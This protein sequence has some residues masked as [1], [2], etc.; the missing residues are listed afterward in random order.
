VL[1]LQHAARPEHGGHLVLGH[2]D[3]LAAQ[4]GRAGD[5]AVGADVDGRVAEDARQEY[6][7]RH[8]GMLVAAGERD[9]IG[10]HADLGNLELAVEYAAVKAFL[11]RQGEVVDLAAFHAH[12]AVHHRADPV[13]V[14]RGDGDGRARHS[15]WMPIDWTSFAKRATSSFTELEEGIERTAWNSA[16]A[17]IRARASG[18]WAAS[19]APRCGAWPPSTA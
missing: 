9:E 6:R 16:V 7:Q 10:R 11:G 18:S 17:A 12:P 13:V 4:V 1:V 15:A 19:R 5:A 3:A 14:P 8:V 2:A